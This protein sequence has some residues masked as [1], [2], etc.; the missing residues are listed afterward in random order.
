MYIM[1]QYTLYTRVQLTGAEDRGYITIDCKMVTP[2]TK[3]GNK[4]NY[5]S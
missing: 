5:V 2:I 4:R 3:D 1:S